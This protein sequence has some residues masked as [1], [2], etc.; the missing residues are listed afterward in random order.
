MSQWGGNLSEEDACR[1]V[2]NEYPNNECGPFCNPDICNLTPEPSP[3]PT[4]AEPTSTP[5]K[6]PT[7]NPTKMPTDNPT[8][9]PITADPTSSPVVPEPKYCGCHDCTDTVWSTMAGAYPCGDRI[10][11]MKSQWGGSLP[12]EEACAFVSAEFPSVCGPYCDPSTCDGR[13]PLYAEPYTAPADTPSTTS[14]KIQDPLYCFPEYNQRERYANTFGG[15]Y[16]IEAKDG[17]GGPCGPG[18]N[19][20][21]SDTVSYDAST[22]ELSLEYKKIG[23]VWKAS[24]VRLLKSETDPTFSYG[25]F[26]FSIKSVSVYDES[27][28]I[29][30]SA[31]PNDLVL[32]LFSWSTTEDYASHEN[33]NHE[34]DVEISQWGDPSQTNDVQ[35]LI[36]PHHPGGPHFPDRLSSGGESASSSV[37]FDQGGHTYGFTWEPNRI[38]W[39]TTAGGGQSRV[40]STQIAKDACTDDYI[41]CL[42]ANVEIRLNL[43]DMN[44]SSDSFAPSVAGLTDGTRV[45]VVIDDFDFTPS[46]TDHV[47]NGEGCT[48]HC[49]CGPNSICGT[50]ATCEPSA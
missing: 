21:T 26:T 29:V 12:E 47:P 37:D 31:L 43:W 6:L 9:A 2:S 48:K 41:Q 10:E 45:E 17:Q 33:W 27:N 40:Y 32:G 19:A 20:F 24:E 35:F 4:T 23:S 42:P 14:L 30:S 15:T 28:N 44:G 34:V 11:Y 49:Q 1:F 7:D 25:T 39:Y 46:S 3:T 8:P 18:N 38:S 36:Q 22:Q 50:S 5:T 16:I 13:C